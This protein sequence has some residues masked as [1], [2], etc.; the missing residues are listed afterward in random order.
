VLQHTAT[1]SRECCNTLQ[2]TLQSIQHTAT[3][4]RECVALYKSMLSLQHIATRS[5]ECCNTL[6]HTLQEY[7]LC[8][9]LQHTLQSVATHCNTLYRVYSLQRTATRYRETTPCSTLQHTRLHTATHPRECV[10][11]YKSTLSTMCCSV[12][13]CVAVC[14]NVLQ[15]VAVCCTLQEYT[16]N[17]VLQC[18]SGSTINLCILRRTRKPHGDHLFS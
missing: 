7:T 16:L 14:C 6:Q 13:Q 11:L 8:N 12:L 5:R 10:A 15:C 2:H 17:N 9:T 18:V 4:S 3:H 1:H